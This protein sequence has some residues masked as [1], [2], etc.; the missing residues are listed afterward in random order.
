MEAN[1]DLP[2]GFQRTYLP[3]VELSLAAWS[4]WEQ[5]I[6]AGHQCLDLTLYLLSSG[7]SS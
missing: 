5:E 6:L 4:L 1:R 2:S 7:S 3:V